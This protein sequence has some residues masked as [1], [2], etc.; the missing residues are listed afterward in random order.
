MLDD[1]EIGDSSWLEDGR[2]A[3]GEVLATMDKLLKYGIQSVEALD[4][5]ENGVED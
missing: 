1:V 2:R 4:N 5:K 3:I